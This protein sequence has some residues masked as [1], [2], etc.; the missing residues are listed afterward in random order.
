MKKEMGVCDRFRVPK[1]IGGR[2]DSGGFFNE[3]LSVKW[4]VI[5]FCI[6]F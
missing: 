4:C 3:F 6:R 1:L 2:F 5:R